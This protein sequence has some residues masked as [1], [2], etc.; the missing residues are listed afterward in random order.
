MLCG[1]LPET[2]MVVY[3]EVVYQRPFLVPI[4]KRRQDFTQSGA[5]KYLPTQIASLY[6]HTFF[7]SNKLHKKEIV[8]TPLCSFC[9]I[10][11]QTQKHF[12]LSV[13]QLRSSGMTQ[14]IGCPMVFT[15]LIS[16]HKMP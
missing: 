14:E 6:T 13:K 8:N 16:I 11:N 7:S 10:E 2:N 15:F 9:E 12:S 1:P 5:Q 4:F 3:K